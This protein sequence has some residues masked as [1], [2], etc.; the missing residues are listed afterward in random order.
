[1][2]HEETKTALWYLHNIVGAIMYYPEIEDE[3]GWF[4]MHI[5]CSPQ[6]IFDSISQVIVR[7]LQMLH[8]NSRVPACESLRRD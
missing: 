4:K 5:I 8:S 3:D 7:S 2:D 1:M 6:V